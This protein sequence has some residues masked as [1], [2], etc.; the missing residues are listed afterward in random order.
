MKG[1]GLF[2]FIT[3]FL[4]L[5]FVPSNFA[6]SKMDKDKIIDVIQS[7]PKQFQIVIFSIIK[8]TDEIK[9]KDMQGKNQIF[10]RKIFT[11]DIYNYIQQIQ[12]RK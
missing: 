4:L 12:L 3:I 6:N 11:G 1:L 7:A 2:S 10:D 8:L 5:A 9:R